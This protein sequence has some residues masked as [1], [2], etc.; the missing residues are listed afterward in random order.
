MLALYVATMLARQTPCMGLRDHRPKN[1]A[2]PQR[3][4]GLEKRLVSVIL[5]DCPVS[6]GTQCLCHSWVKEILGYGSL[7]GNGADLASPM[8]HATPVVDGT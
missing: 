2:L 7:G 8:R 4:G 1:K 6:I 3:S 5:T